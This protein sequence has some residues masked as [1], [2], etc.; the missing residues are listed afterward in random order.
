MA[1]NK[2]YF[3]SQGAIE[4]FD[5]TTDRGVLQSAG[6][7]KVYKAGSTIPVKFQL[8]DA[9]N[10]PVVNAVARL[11]Y[12]KLEDGLPGQE[13]EAVHPDRPMMEMY[14]G[15]VL[16]VTSISSILKQGDGSWENIN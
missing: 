11:Y 8:C 16:T 13:N 7:D 12:A 5:L 15:I 9:N 3:N 10:N 1:Y 2:S 6:K 14:S 4:Y